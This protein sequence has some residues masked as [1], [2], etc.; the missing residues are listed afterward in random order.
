MKHVNNK[1]EHERE[2]NDR[3]VVEEAKKGAGNQR[4]STKD[5]QSEAERENHDPN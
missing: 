2:T 1:C 3:V 5:K 4:W